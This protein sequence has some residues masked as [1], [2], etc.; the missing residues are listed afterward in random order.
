[1]MAKVLRVLL[2]LAVVLAVIGYFRSWYAVSKIEEET[3][4]SIILKIDRQRVREDLQL[5][6]KRVDEMQQKIGEDEVPAGTQEESLPLAIP[7]SQTR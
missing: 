7:P 6:R 3:T 2:V 1:M 5:A 4:T